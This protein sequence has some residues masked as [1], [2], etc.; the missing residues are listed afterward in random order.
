MHETIT[1]LEEAFREQALGQAI[2]PV[3]SSIAIA[4]KDG[5]IGIMPAY[6]EGLQTFSTKIVSVYNKNPARNLPTIMATIVLND[7]ETGEALSVMDGSFITAMRTGGLGGLTAKYL[8]R[9]DSRTVGIFGAGVQGRTHLMA[10]KEVRTITSAK[11]YDPVV[12]RAKTYSQEMS[13]KLQIPVEVSQSPSDTVKDSD[14]VVTVSTSKEPL[15]DGRILRPGTHINAF[16][17]FK[18]TERELDNETIRRS[19]V[20]V[21]LREAALSEA[22]DLTM[23][24]ND[25]VITAGHILAD[26][27]EVII[28]SKPVRTSSSDITLFK[29]VGLGIQDCAASSLAYKKA[30]EKGVGTRINLH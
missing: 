26:L 12:E 5:W 9:K 29:S 27:G 28:G 23:P 11:V 30:L 15:F 10:L 20:V 3:R 24:I 7:P 14:I 21:D 16:G 22:G 2:A 13:K 17:N 18:L 8:S 4:K 6:L 25:G 19:K 1:A